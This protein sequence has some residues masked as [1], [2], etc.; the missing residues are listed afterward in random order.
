MYDCILFDLD[1]TLT[2]PKPGITGSV[3]HALRYFGI[4]VENM[5]E[6]EC[7]IGPPLKESF[8][9]YY[10]LTDRQADT[11]MEKYREVFSVTGLFENRVYPGMPQALQRLREGGR[12]LGVATSK[13]EIYSRRILEHFQLEGYFAGL[14]GSELD[15]RRVDKGEVI[16]EAMRRLSADPRHTLMV[17]DRLHDV[18]GAKKAGIACLGVAYGYG[19]RDELQAAGADAVADTVEAM[20]DWILAH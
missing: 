20:A 13:P 19:G 4:V 5:D 17:G 3:A 15:G 11:A 12:T 1:G 14:T 6:L 9:R 2:D 18:E 7:F 8:M 16:L 10:G